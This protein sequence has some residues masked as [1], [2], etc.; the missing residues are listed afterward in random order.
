[1]QTRWK[2]SPAEGT[3][4]S[5]ELQERS[6]VTSAS[7]DRYRSLFSA[8]QEG[9][10]LAEMVRG[11]DGRIDFRYL[12]INPAAEQMLGLPRDEVVGLTARALIPDVREEMLALCAEV[13]QTGVPQRRDVYEPMVDQYHQSLFFRP[14]EGQVAILFFDVTDRKRSE[15]ELARTAQTLAR[16]RERLDLLVSS[17]DDHLVVYDREWRYVVVHDAA[18]DTLGM[19]KEDLLGRSIWELFPGAVGNQ[20]WTKLHEAVEHQHVTHDEHYYAPFDKWFENH[21]YPTHDGVTVFSTDITARKKAEEA[22]HERDEELREADRRKD[23]FLA[24][25]AHEL[26]N[27]LSAISNAVEILMRSRDDG[28]ATCLATGILRRQVAHMTRQVDDLLDVSR[29]SRGRIEL[30]TERVDLSRL[31]HDVLQATAPT[32]AGD[33]ALAVTV[34]DA[35]VWVSGDPVRLGQVVGNVLSNAYKF[36]DTGD[37]ICLSLETGEESAVLRIRDTGMGIAPDQLDR[38]FEMFAQADTSLERNRDGLGIG[39]TLVRAL[40]ALHGGT[41]EARSAGVGQ[42][43]EFIIQLPLESELPR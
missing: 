17:I 8:M 41:V 6:G 40:V 36:T 39:L 11:A 19:R 13:V 4:T 35:A 27:P 23:E 1:M 20:Y 34:P 2:G 32:R 21:I 15:E 7:D 5:G 24:M 28:D 3:T 38:I 22:L 43:S 26:R 10:L 16:E 37:S 12:D 18:T 31:L 14:A 30:K 25:L 42:G 29:I 9:L 33:R